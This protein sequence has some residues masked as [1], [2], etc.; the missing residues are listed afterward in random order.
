MGLEANAYDR[1]LKMADV[2]EDDDAKE[3]F[4]TIAKEEKGHL[5]KLGELLDQVVGKE[6]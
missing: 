1:Y 2:S 6:I 3:M 5:R 4:L